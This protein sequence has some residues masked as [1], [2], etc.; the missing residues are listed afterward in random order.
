[1][2]NQ[3]ENQSVHLCTWRHMRSRTTCDDAAY[4][5]FWPHP[6]ISAL[7]FFFFFFFFCEK[8]FLFGLGTHTFG[9]DGG[10]Q[11]YSCPRWL[12]V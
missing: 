9:K 5:H 2:H 11:W 6:F 3:C 4:V 1:M 7:N 10:G 12:L 8:K